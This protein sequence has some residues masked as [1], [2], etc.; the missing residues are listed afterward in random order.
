MSKKNNVQTVLLF[1][2]IAPN[3]KA[4]QEQQSYSANTYFNKAQQFFQQKNITRSIELYKK[5]ISVDPQHFEAHFYLANTY[6]QRGDYNNA[7]MFYKK[8]QLIRNYMPQVDFNLALVLEASGKIDEAIKQLRGA[9]RKNPSYLKAKI[10]LAEY[11][12][13]QKKEN[14]A[15]EL[16]Y[17]ALAQ[18]PNNFDSLY[19][20]ASIY[21]DKKDLQKAITFYNKALAIRPNDLRANF[22][23]G[24]TYNLTN[25]L[26]KAKEAYRTILKIAPHSIDARYNLAHTLR[27]TGESEES[28]EHYRIVLEKRPNKTGAHYGYAES[29][30][31]MGD[32]EKGW[33]EFEWRWK[34]GGDPRNFS[35]KLWDGSEISGKTILIRAEYGL[36]D[37]IQFIRFAKQLKEQ[38][39]TIIVQI[40]SPLAQ[41]LSLC[42]YIDEIVV[43]GDRLPDF[44]VQ[45]PIMS[46]PFKLG[47]TKKENIPNEVPY[48]EAD[49]DLVRYWQ[50]EISRD[51]NFKIGICWEGSSY[52][53]SLRGPLSKKALHLSVFEPISR[54]PY[55]TLYSLQ[56]TSEQ[57]QI[58]EVSFEVRN[59]GPDFD[60]T[61][62][63]FMDSAALMKNLDLV[64]TIDTSVAHLAGA[65][66]T[67]VWVVLPTVADWR[68]LTEVED[69]PWYP[70]MK[71]FRQKVHGDWTHVF[72]K[73]AQ[74]LSGLLQKSKK[75]SDIVF[76]EISIGELID[77]I[78][79]LRLKMKHIK[80]EA[81]LANVKKELI[82]LCKTLDTK[83]PKC[84]KLDD[85]TQQLYETNQQLWD[86]ED[87]CR[88]KERNKEFDDEFIQITRSVYITNDKRCALKRKIN[89]LLGSNLV[90][91]KSYAAY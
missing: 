19:S 29:L 84:E 61:N 43:I 86:I 65:L 2:L 51:G 76:A 59:F 16:Y 53:D 6:F 62:G 31:R 11:L 56:K 5:A 88:N 18:D 63:R 50:K 75:K 80:D 89:T 69:T 58:D 70:Q 33:Q 40:Q 78:T 64:I 27:Y 13:K 55:V 47:V 38:G 46:L 42:P 72:E 23:L 74:A 37:S 35:E 1:L 34:R 45:V 36:G 66:S 22:D 39:A 12:L 14:L 20:I 28:S 44:D 15:L 21:R 7:I 3:L 48:L 73:V 25:E 91:E 17:D 41:L 67:P 77:K 32:F 10:L 54:I 85:L 8:A 9:L 4:S 24:F 90:E 79:I 57:N 81:K 26:T 68:W 49:P 30:L 71:L 60:K 83:V 87:D 52:Y 82:S